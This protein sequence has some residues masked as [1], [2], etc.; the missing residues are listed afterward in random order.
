M[1]LYIEPTG[2]P[3]QFEEFNGIKSY[4]GKDSVGCSGRGEKSTPLCREHFL[5]AAAIGSAKVYDI[6][7]KREIE[8]NLSKRLEEV[9]AF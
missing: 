1:T 5:Y 8:E 3:C 9:L 4:C 6:D 2:K 7:G